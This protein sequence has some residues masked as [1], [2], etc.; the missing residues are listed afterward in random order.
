MV[1]GAGLTVWVKGVAAVLAAKLMGA[2]AQQAVILQP[3]DRRLTPAGFWKNGGGPRDTRLG[4]SDRVRGHRAS[5]PDAER[6][7]TLGSPRRCDASRQQRDARTPTP[8]DRNRFHD[9]STL[10][11]RSQPCNHPLSTIDYPG[12][13]TFR[14]SPP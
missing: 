1:V 8:R 13:D 11:D 4:Q 7:A 5:L 14:C 12:D 3:L 2:R 6:F 9:N 10:T